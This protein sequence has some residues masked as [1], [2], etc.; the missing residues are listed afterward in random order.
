M[1]DRENTLNLWISSMLGDMPYTLTLLAQDA[2]FRRYY[3]LQYQGVSR[4]IMDAPPEK[5]SIVPFLQMR[6][7]LNQASVLTPNIHARED[8]QGFLLLEDWGDH[9]FLHSLKPG[10]TL[11]FYQNALQIL[12][13]MQQISEV[14]TLTPFDYG[15]MRKEMELFIT[16]FLQG[17]L[18]LTL[19][20]AEEQMIEDSLHH[21]ADKVNQQRT[22]FI[23]RDFHS[24]NLMV[25]Q[26]DP[27]TLGVLDFQDAML[28]PFTYDLV[29]ILKDCYIRW[30]REQVLEWIQAFHQASPQTSTEPLEDFIV[31]FDYCG[32][33]RHLKVLGV[34]SR[35]HLR[36][37]KSAYLQDLPLTLQYV[38]ECTNIY[39]ELTPLHHFLQNRV[40]LP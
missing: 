28:G 25:I 2:S 8:N 11:E 24:R 16:W 39:A 36:D 7:I 40:H 34:F 15:F 21:I 35:L 23:H 26:S 9:L 20:F 6:E 33:Q 22:C 10:N 37:N 38:L 32:L 13:Q 30:P 27:L 29:S 18:S 31:A 4:V 5:E 1:Q 3:R 12:L 19:S 14:H 17:Y